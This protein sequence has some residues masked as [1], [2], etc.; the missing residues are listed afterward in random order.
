MALTQIIDA[1]PEHWIY[2]RYERSML[3]NIAN[4]IQQTWPAEN[5]LLLNLTWT[6]PQTW[7]QLH[8]VADRGEAIDNLFLVATVDAVPIHTRE[9]VDFLAREIG[10]KKIHYLGNWE[11]QHYFNF[12]AIVCRHHF[13]HYAVDDLILQDPRY[14]YICY[15]RKPYP[16]RLFLVKDLL[17]H[18]LDSRG[19]ITLGKPEPGNLVPGQLYPYLTIGEREEDYVKYGHWY[20][21]GVESTPHEIPHDLFSL[22]NWDR[23]QHHFLHIIGTTAFGNNEPVFVNQIDFKPIIGLRPWI[24]NGQT[25]HY[26]F[27][28]DHGFR[29]FS[30]W[31]RDIDLEC[32]RQDQ[33][34]RDQILRV[35]RRLYAMSRD[36][37]LSMYRAMLPD[38]L[39]NRQRFYEWAAEQEHRVNNLFL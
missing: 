24:V 25:K 10:V 12:F 20:E 33:Y 7:D 8:S 4:Q 16:H 30:H 14:L 6:G 36:E 22:H 2:G 37:I 19:V 39:Y 32:V 17:W 34:S 3:S 27:F 26:Q 9:Y 21:P 13:E 15:N 5:N 11:G 29:T 35:V 38:L 18:R 28:R 23:W 31:F 1:F